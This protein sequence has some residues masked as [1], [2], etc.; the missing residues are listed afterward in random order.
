MKKKFGFIG[1]VIICF[2][3]SV[4]PTQA[5][6]ETDW[7]YCSHTEVLANGNKRAVL[8]A[9]FEVAEGTYH[10]GTENDFRA[11]LQKEYPNAKFGGRFSCRGPFE[12]SSDASASYMSDRLEFR[13]LGYNVLE[14]PWA[15]W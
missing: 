3:S 12:S 5:Q 6:T 7:T 2:L 14:T 9:L 4:A 8:S 13:R 15:G 11:Y 10:V 1:A